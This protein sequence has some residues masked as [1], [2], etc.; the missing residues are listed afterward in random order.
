MTIAFDRGEDLRTGNAATAA[1]AGMGL[2]SEGRHRGTS[3]RHV[4]RH[5][6]RRVET[7]R[8]I[9]IR[10]NSS[11]GFEWICQRIA[12]RR[13]DR[14]RVAKFISGVGISNIRFFA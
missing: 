13:R 4:G 1:H 3:S 2:V 8:C 12:T 10:A 5:D 9:S 6:D 14:C 11:R 7:C